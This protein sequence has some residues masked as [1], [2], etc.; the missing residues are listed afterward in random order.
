MNPGLM[1][2][3]GFV[4]AIAGRLLGCIVWLL[5]PLLRCTPLGRFLRTGPTSGATLARLAL[6]AAAGAAGATA[7]FFDGD[8]LRPSSAF[9]RS[10]DAAAR[11]QA[12]APTC[13]PP[14]GL[15]CAQPLGTQL[16]PPPLNTMIPVSCPPPEARFERWTERAAV[17]GDSPATPRTPQ[18]RCI[19]AVP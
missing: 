1:L 8:A 13:P 19:F 3:T 14:L 11:Y 10:A 7:A 4:S 16:T 2:D 18:H 5:T 15:H 6:P 9:S 12:V 17:P